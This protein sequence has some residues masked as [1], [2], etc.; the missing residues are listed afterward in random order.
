MVP[1]SEW[2]KVRPVRESLD[3]P[4]HW[5]A[6]GLD[7]AVPADESDREIGP[8]RSPASHGLECRLTSPAARVNQVPQDHEVGRGGE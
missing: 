3:A 5:R 4:R 7:V 2:A 6:S 1:E 8:G